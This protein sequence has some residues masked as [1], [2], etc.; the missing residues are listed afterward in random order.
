MLASSNLH[1][2]L[3]QRPSINPIKKVLS[4]TGGVTSNG[5]I[6]QKKQPQLQQI[7]IEA[8]E[9]NGFLIN[10][11]I[12]KGLYY[13]YISTIILLIILFFSLP[14]IFFFLLWN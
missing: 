1:L 9:I 11:S 4:L 6:E 10:F 13:L 5:R 14:F 12:F 3:K 2:I 7:I 8:A